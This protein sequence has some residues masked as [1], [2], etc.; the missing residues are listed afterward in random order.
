MKPRRFPM[1][2]KVY[3]LAGGNEDNDLWVEQAAFA[4]GTPYIRSVWE[5]T[6]D[7]RR[8]VAEGHNISLTV[9]GEGTPPVQ[10]RVT[11]ELLGKAD[12]GGR[13]DG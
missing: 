11:S 12:K 9:I 2:N 1:A 8:R 3:S 5:L 13:D 4:D 6:D 10:I 7:E